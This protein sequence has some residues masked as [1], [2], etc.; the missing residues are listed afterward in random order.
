MTRREL[1]SPRKTAIK[2]VWLKSLAYHLHRHLLR[3]DTLQVSLPDTGLELVVPVQDMVGRHIYK[4]GAHD[5]EMVRFLREFLAPEPGDVI[6]DIGAHIGWYSLILHQLVPPGVEIFAFEPHPANLGLLREN[7]D[8]NDA[9][10]VHV[11]P[12]ALSDRVGEQ[13][14]FEYSG[15]NTGRHSLL[16]LHRGQTLRVSTVTLD[17]FWRQRGLGDRVPRF[18]KIDVEGYELAALRSGEQVLRRCPAVLMEY[19]PHFMRAA[20]LDPVGLSNLMFSMGFHCSRIDSGSA[21]GMTRDA[22]EAC[23]V[24]LNLLWRRP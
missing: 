3:S 22:L 23:N 11:V 17:S 12:T 9:S 10:G 7:L 8:R 16:P 1:A 13:D 15:P 24:Q 2:T 21:V 18:I 20:G 6:L 5:P 14:L 19:S 4:Y